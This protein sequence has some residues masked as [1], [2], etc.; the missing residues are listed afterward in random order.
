MHKILVP[1]D[2]SSYSMKAFEYSLEMAAEHG[3]TVMMLNVYFLA[4]VNARAPVIKE[5]LNAIEAIQERTDLTVITAEEDDS[6]PEEKSN[7]KGRKVYCELLVRQG[8]VE[9]EIIN[10]AVQKEADLIMMGTHG[11]SGL[12]YWLFGSSTAEVIEKSEHP[13]LAV[14]PEADFNKIEKV[15]YATDLTTEKDPALAQLIRF[16]RYWKAE[17]QMIHV[18]NPEEA[19]NTDQLQYL[20]EDI[21][22]HHNLDDILFFEVE[23]KSIINGI[24]EHIK[25]QNP[26]IIAM[27]TQYRGFLQKIMDSSKTSKMALEGKVPVLAFHR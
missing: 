24:L 14:P 27:T 20:A 25:E 2:L 15:V 17:L 23:N 1:T 7:E 4:D 16:V 22:E 10:T 21:S 18:R 26:D 13:V 11:A 9:E 3:G 6:W 5:M 12:G 19:P 8:F